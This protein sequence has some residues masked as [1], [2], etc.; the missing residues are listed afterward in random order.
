MAWLILLIVAWGALAFGPFVNRNHSAD[1]MLL[2]LP[3][4]VGYFAS[5]VGVNSLFSTLSIVV[6]LFSTLIG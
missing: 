2:A 3:V 4:A 6:V 1:W 5:L